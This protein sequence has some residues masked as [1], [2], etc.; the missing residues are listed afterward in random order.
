L[1]EDRKEVAEALKRLESGNPFAGIGPAP[2]DFA[3]VPILGDKIKKAQA[4]PD[5]L[6]YKIRTNAYKYGWALIPLSLPFV[7]LVTIGPGMRAYRLYD[8]L[9]FTTY[10]IG[11]MML[12]GIALS[13]VNIAGVWADSLF[14]IGLSYAFFHMYRQLRGAYRFS[15][16]SALIRAFFLATSSVIALTLFVL[17]LVGL[18]L[19]G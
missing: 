16:A 9:V 11:F 4:N 7:W 13:L 18:G 6:L 12:M 17:I 19:F 5:L 8:H 14:V 1:R 3:G 10:S 15:R 2:D